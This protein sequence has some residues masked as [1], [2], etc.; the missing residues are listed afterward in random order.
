MAAE[1]RRAV[2]TVVRLRSGWALQEFD[3]SYLPVTPPSVSLSGRKYKKRRSSRV[4]GPELCVVWIQFRAGEKHPAFLGHPA[5]RAAGAG[6]PG[7][8]H[9]RGEAP[10]RSQFTESHGGGPER[11]HLRDHPGSGSVLR[12]RL[13]ELYVSRIQ[14]T[15]A[16]GQSPRSWS[17]QPRRAEQQDGAGPAPCLAPLQR[18]SRKNPLNGMIRQT[19]GRAA[20]VAPPHDQRPRMLAP[21]RD[22]R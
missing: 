13:R 11:S 4:S 9:G 15:A 12:S 19:A 16:V 1:L 18:E 17:R 2:R 3:G 8:R 22:P 7:G 10:L 6:P 20:G 5:T 14:F 21:G